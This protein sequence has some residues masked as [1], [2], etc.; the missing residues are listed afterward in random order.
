[1]AWRELNASHDWLEFYKEVQPLC[2]TLPQMVYHQE[3]ILDALLSRLEMR[4]ALSLE[5]LLDLLVHLSR[6]LASDF[7]PHFPRMVEAIERVVM[8]CGEVGGNASGSQAPWASTVAGEGAEQGAPQRSSSSGRDGS[9]PSNYDVSTQA[10]HA[11]NLKAAFAAL[12]GVCKNLAAYLVLDL[13]P[14]FKVTRGLRGHRAADVRRLAGDALGYLARRASDGVARSGVRYLMDEIRDSWMDST[15]SNSQAEDNMDAAAN[16]ERF[17]TDRQRVLHLCE[18]NGALLASAIKGVKGGLHSRCGRILRTVFCASRDP[19]EYEVDDTGDVSDAGDDV[20]VRAHPDVPPLDGARDGGAAVYATKHAF[21]MSCFEYVRD[22]ELLDPVWEAVLGHCRQV[23]AGA[24]SALDIAR[25]SQLVTSLVGHRGGSRVVAHVDAV[26]DL[27]DDLFEYV[28]GVLR[29]DQPDPDLQDGQEGQRPDGVRGHTF[30]TRRFHRGYVQ[31]ANVYVHSYLEPSLVASLLDLVGRFLRVLCRWRILTSERYG[32]RIASWRDGFDAMDTETYV[33]FVQALLG[34]EGL[35]HSPS[36]PQGPLAGPGAHAHS[37]HMPS[38]HNQQKE[39]WDALADATV[40]LAFEKLSNEL[41]E[42]PECGFAWE[43]AVALSNLASRAPKA[44]QSN[45]SRAVMYAI[46]SDSPEVVWAAIQVGASVCDSKQTADRFYAKATERASNDVTVSA[47]TS[48]YL[49]LAL[50]PSPSPAAPSPRLALVAHVHSCRVDAICRLAGMGLA[51]NK[52]DIS[53]LANSLESLL[54]QHPADRHLL[55]AAAKLVTVFPLPFATAVSERLLDEVSASLSSPSGSMRVDCLKICISLISGGD[56]H[57][58]VAAPS[59]SVADAGAVL[60]LLLDLETH[61]LGAESGRHATVALSRIQNLIEYRRIPDVVVM[62]CVR[63]LLGLLHF[64]LSSYW[65]PVSKALAAAIDAFPEKAWPILVESLRRVEREVQMDIADDDLDG[66]VDDVD[67]EEVE[68]VEDVE[69]ELGEGDEGSDG[70]DGNGHLGGVYMHTRARK[71]VRISNGADVHHAR[72]ARPSSFAAALIADDPP[73][74]DATARLSHHIKTLSLVSAGLLTSRSRDWVPIFLRF[75]SDEVTYRLPLSARRSVLREWLKVLQALKKNVKG[76]HDSDRVLAAVCSR[77]MD[78]DPLVQSTVL[79]TL[80]PFDLKWLN[81]YLDSLLRLADN[82]TLRSELTAFQLDPSSDF[83]QRDHRDDIVPFLIAALFP[84]LRKRNGRLGGKGAPGSARA[85]ILNFLSAAHPTEL[86]ALLELFLLPMADCFLVEQNSPEEPTERTEPIKGCE[87][88]IYLADTATSLPRLDEAG[89]DWLVRIDVRFLGAQPTNRH[90]GYL[91]AID[92]LVK[93]LGFKLVG[94]LPMITSLIAKMLRLAVENDDK[95][96]RIKC[97]RLFSSIVRSHGAHIPSS[98]Y[99]DVFRSVEQ[100][101]P[102]I[103]VECNAERPPALVELCA[104]VVSL[105]NPA[106]LVPGTLLRGTL[107]TLL[108]PHCSSGCASAV[109]GIVECIIDECNDVENK[110]ARVDGAGGDI[111]ALLH[112]ADALLSGLDCILTG[113]RKHRALAVRS[114]NILEALSSSSF[115]GNSGRIVEALLSMLSIPK[116]KWQCDDRRRLSSSN[117]VLIARACACLAAMFGGNNDGDDDEDGSGAKNDRRRQRIEGLAPLVLVLTTQD[118]RESFCVALTSH[119]ACRETHLL[120]DLNAFSLTDPDYDRRLD[121]YGRLATDF[122][123]S[124]SEESRGFHRF[125]VYQCCVDLASPNDLSLRHSAARALGRLLEEVSSQSV[126]DRGMHGGTIPP[127]PSIA[128]DAGVTLVKNVLMPEIRLR[129]AASASQTVRQEHVEMVRLV[130]RRLPK[131]FPELQSITHEE[132]DLDFWSNVCHVQLHRRARAFERIR[133]ICE[134]TGLDAKLIENYLLVLIEKAVEDDDGKG[135][136][137]ASVTDAAVG[138]LGAFDLEEKTFLRVLERFVSLC[139]KG[140]GHRTGS[141]STGKGYLRAVSILL[142]MNGAARC[143]EPPAAAGGRGHLLGDPAGDARSAGNAGD[144]PV[145]P[146]ARRA[147]HASSVAFVEFAS[148]KLIPFLHANLEDRKRESVRGPVAASMVKLLKRLP[149]DTMRDQLPKILQ[150]VCNLLRARLQRIRDDAREVLIGLATELGDKYLMYVLHVLKSSLP[151]RGFTAHVLG[152][153]TYFVMEG[154]DVADSLRIADDSL[155][156]VILSIVEGDLFG[157]VAEAKEASEFASSYKESK[158]CK[159]YDILRCVHARVHSLSLIFTS[160][161]RRLCALTKR[162]IHPPGRA[163]HDVSLLSLVPHPDSLTPTRLPCHRRRILGK[164]IQR[165]EDL[166]RVL[167][168]VTERSSLADTPKTR[169]KI[170]TLLGAFRKGLGLGPDSISVS[171]LVCGVAGFSGDDALK[172]DQMMEFALGVANDRLAAMASGGQ[173][174]GVP[175]AADGPASTAETLRAIQPVAVQTISSSKRSGCVVEA[176]RILKACRIHGDKRLGD[177]VGVAE[178][179]N[180]AEVGDHLTVDRGLEGKV[181]GTG[182]SIPYGSIVRAALNAS[183]ESPIG[184]ETLALLTD[185]VS[186]KRTVLDDRAMGRVIQWAGVSSTDSYRLHKALIKARRVLPEVYDSMNAVAS[187]M[188]KST[189][190]TVRQL[191]SSTMLAY[192]LDYPLGKKRLDH[193]VEFLLSNMG[194]RHSEGGRQA[195][196]ELLCHLARKFPAG[197]RRRFYDKFV[198]FAFARAANEESRD[199]RRQV[200]D[201][202]LVRGLASPELYGKYLGTFLDIRYAYYYYDN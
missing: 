186:S 95:E 171:N 136:V 202:L 185:A 22:S 108:A 182:G 33:D 157:D 58:A 10:L 190:K 40:P 135:G 113:F 176:L 7:V 189:D 2:S 21:M 98:V 159:G 61:P 8:G 149:E 103:A 200:V 193:H 49:S 96:V 97:I 175:A 92:D 82:K 114:L 131:T 184:R 134:S 158:R 153:T 14:V 118:A 168:W 198:F 77:I 180:G 127:V 156:T 51:V 54:G 31:S 132:D 144:P 80:R 47:K 53:S 101:I 71:R 160:L 104:S 183:P 74:A 16:V 161:H 42:D 169:N 37:T 178:D 59:T 30:G 150:V 60:S 13:R 122:L 89:C 41:S 194:Y 63:G 48:E 199:V 167:S 123:G 34:R 81:P 125:L 148:T 27:L 170:T 85:A 166:I 65:G 120:K 147:S 164:R 26:F 107:D 78:I 191:A 179:A 110:T 91:N 165:E 32:A 39:S 187:A 25:M 79:Q 68:D 145:A 137:S 93:H 188:V 76:M 143:P 4:Y 52:K 20:V 111:T 117:E 106:A 99:G 162:S 90:V 192:I 64:K 3:A 28:T 29:T 94:Y 70:D 126:Y 35:V 100:F 1:M 197:I 56:Q 152:Y 62:P 86:G 163:V 201:D 124:S 19:E 115:F 72:G 151:M 133:R 121:A 116:R 83:I 173:R 75:V 140:T 195:V 69:G 112:H 44:S 15:V 55:A 36:G 43:G 181:S 45:F 102:L 174:P 109:L 155:V 12:S 9:R 6:D 24:P 5:P 172:R 88:R 154:L 146:I 57:P 18:G 46:D 177:D 50:S 128:A 119:R 142:E 105:Q 67:D 17:N 130:A 141:V 138:C 139:T 129:M 11:T 84:R 73:Q 87:P 196:C 38:Q 23:L 66:D